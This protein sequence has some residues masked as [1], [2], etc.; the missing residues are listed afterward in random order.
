MT[1]ERAMRFNAGKPDYSLIPPDA[2]RALA[3][4]YTIGALKHDVSVVKTFEEA[5]EW[6]QAAIN[7]LLPASTQIVPL[8]PGASVGA[9]TSATS[10]SGTRTTPNASA[11]TNASGSNETPTGLPKSNDARWS[12]MSPARN[13]GRQNANASLLRSLGLDN[14]VSPIFA[15]GSTGVVVYASD[16]SEPSR[17]F[18]WIITIRR[19]VSEVCFAAAAT[20]ASGCFATAL[21]FLKAQLPIS[22][23]HLPDTCTSDA[24]GGL[25]FKVSGKH[26]WLKGMP[27]SEVLASAE[28]HLEA[29]KAGEDVDPDTGLPHAALLAWNGFCLTTYL[30][31]GLGEDD[32]V[33][34]TD[35]KPL[36]NAL[37]AM[38]RAGLVKFDGRVFDGP[39]VKINPPA[40]AP[41]RLPAAVDFDA[42]EQALKAPEVQAEARDG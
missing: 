29:I 21:S 19:G 28:R 18:M 22:S 14:K 34:I 9:A 6:V 11:S 33:K 41:D 5:A 32:R 13:V 1:D 23:T 16:L 39:Q 3:W 17:A 37:D 15:H 40:S 26:N 31:R 20:T 24:D 36:F 42:L 27:W 25:R 30:L 10:N 4:V 35:N 2:L 8:R 12:E 38:G 7:S